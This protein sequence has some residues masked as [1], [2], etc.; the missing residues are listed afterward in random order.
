MLQVDPVVSIDVNGRTNTNLDATC[1]AGAAFYTNGIN[2]E[3]T[4][5]GG[6]SNVGNW[7]DAGDAA[8]VWIMWTRTGGTLSDW[9]NL[10]AG[11]NNVRRQATSSVTYRLARTGSGVSTIIG[12]F[13]A[14]D[15]ATG[16]NL[17]DTGSTG[18]YSAEYDIE[19]CPL[20]C[21]TP[22]TPVSM[23]SG[24]EMPIGKVRAGDMIA[25]PDGPQE[26][27]EVLIR[28]RRRM[29]RI[30]FEDG[31]YLDASDDHPLEVDGKGPSAINP[32]VPY[33]DL[34]MPEV[35]EVGDVVQGLDRIHTITAIREIDYPG[36]VYT[37][38]NSPFYANG[39]LVY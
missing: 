26:V 6:L 21:F 19:T 1:Y 12:Y 4:A 20:C 38:S 39:I 18:T 32:L 25:T 16:G 11:Y 28:E 36:Q 13:R 5:T 23:A 9:N 8:D 27:G 15:A 10:G 30:Q 17:L 22:D 37:F 7:L 33:K 2:Y 24:I 3:Y 29:Y 31:R 35:I 34:G 14:Y